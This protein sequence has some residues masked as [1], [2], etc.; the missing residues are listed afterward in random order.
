MSD[1]QTRTVDIEGEQIEVRELSA[2][3]LMAINEKLSERNGVE[4]PNTI[5]RL[6]VIDRAIGLELGETERRS[7]DWKP[8]KFLAW[9]NPVS[10]AVTDLNDMGNE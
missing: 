7:K 1:L 5:M 10:A 2:F 3:D 9:F 6:L 4:A 8:A